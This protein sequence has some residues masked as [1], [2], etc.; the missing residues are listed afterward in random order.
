MKLELTTEI[1]EKLMDFGALGYDSFQMSIILDIEH[2]L[3]EEF[4]NDKSSE[5]F[6]I[7][8]KGMYTA[9]YMVDKKQFDQALN[10]DPR[11]MDNFAFAMKIRLKNENDR[12]KK[13]RGNVS[14]RS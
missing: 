3:I 2:K 4:M 1:E 10:G 11:A 14:K 5:F 12:S 13:P 7:Y 8:Q 6:M 9:K